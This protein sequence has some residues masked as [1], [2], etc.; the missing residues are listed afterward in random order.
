MGRGAGADAGRVGGGVG[1][2]GGFARGNGEPVGG[3]PGA[4]F[5]CDR[6][7]RGETAAAVGAPAGGGATSYTITMTTTT[8]FALMQLKGRL[9]LAK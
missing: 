3:E 4:E 5:E 7:G 2:C 8:C 1:Q 6:S 9:V